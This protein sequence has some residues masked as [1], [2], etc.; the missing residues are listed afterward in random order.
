MYETM[1]YVFEREQV[2]FRFANGK[3]VRKEIDR[4]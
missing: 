3:I 4:L 1:N 2:D